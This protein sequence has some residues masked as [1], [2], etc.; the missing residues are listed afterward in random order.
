M[1]SQKLYLKEI[2]VERDV[3]VGTGVRNLDRM[4][5]GADIVLAAGTVVTRSTE[6]YSVSGGVPARQIRTCKPV[7]DASP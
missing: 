6:P 7:V 3:C 5:T 1:N 4:H 2:S